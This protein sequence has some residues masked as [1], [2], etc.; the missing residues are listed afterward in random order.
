MSGGLENFDEI[1]RRVETGFVPILR[2][3]PGF[4]GYS[5]VDLQAAITRYFA[6]HNA[7]LEPFA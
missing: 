6:K 2:E 4:W 7:D 3:S 5:L 1:A